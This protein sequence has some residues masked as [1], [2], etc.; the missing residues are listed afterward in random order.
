MTPKGC[1]D[2][3]MLKKCG[4]NGTCTK[5]SAGVASCVCDT[6]FVL[7]TDNRTCTDTCVLKRCGGNGT[8]TKESDG[9]A[10]CVCNV[11][12][13][14]QANNRTCTD[15]CVLKACGGNGTC[16]KDSAGVA[17][18][19]CDVGFV[20]QTNGRTC[21]DTCVLKKCGGNATCIKSST[22]VA[23]CVCNTG[24]MLQPGGTTC[25]DTCA[26][27]AC[28]GNGTCT[29]DSAGV[30]SCVC[31][32]GF[33]LQSD[34]RTCTDTC[35]L[36]RCG[37]N[38]TCVKSTAGV[39]SCVCDSGFEI[40]PDG[41]TCTESCALKACGGN[42]R[43]TKDSAGVASCVCDVGFA[44]QT[45]G[46]T[47]TDTCVLKNCA[48]DTKCV[49]SAAGVASCVCDTDFV[50]QPDGVTCTVMCLLDS[51][52]HSSPSIYLVPLPPS[53]LHADTCAVKSCNLTVSVCMKDAAGMA[54]CVYKTGYQNVSGPST[55][56]VCPAGASCIPVSYSN[57]AYCLFS[58][59]SGMTAVGCVLDATPTVSTTSFTFYTLPSY[60][61]T[62]ATY[63]TRLTY[64]G[65]TNLTASSARDI[66]SY[67]SVQD[68]PGGVGSCLEIRAYYQAGCIGKYNLFPVAKGSLSTSSVPNYYGYPFRSFGC[69]IFEK[70]ALNSCGANGKC[71]QDSAGVAFCAC[72][73]GFV[74]QPDG[75]TCAVG[76][77]SKICDPTTDC[78]RNAAGSATCVCKAGY[79]NIS[80]TCLG[81]ATCGNC[82][83]GATCTVAFGYIPYCICPPGYGMTSTGCISGAVPTV[84]DN[85][86][87]FYDQSNYTITP[88]TYTMRLE[89]NGCTTI[90]SS[91]SSKIRSIWNVQ[92]VSGGVGN[93]ISVNYYT[94]EG[95]VGTYISFPSSGGTGM[96]GSGYINYPT[97]PYRSFTCV[98]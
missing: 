25:T 62:P 19:V 56:G 4:G 49:K 5:D 3:C 87:T 75:R 46:R 64:N 73:A 94:Q 18:C 66:Q 36:K 59:G 54:S 70:C 60:G 71:V 8:C 90:P 12:F 55:C 84:S 92:K 67:G 53:H 17:S 79:R 6:G 15:T 14:L 35:V 10:S 82:P 1:V 58:P 89:Y 80:G 65:C 45:D 63:T 78:V 83:T 52:V 24:F 40:Q 11:G 38:A 37:G 61:V 13:V 95:C 34:G 72:D 47:C 50:L 86:F 9:V 22:G 74:L 33:D 32:T 93:C 81:P 31:D 43:C 77:G 88:N 29:K 48:G 97:Y 27:K 16:T 30:A 39:A 41:T 69:S 7:Q 51:F 28:G 68:A 26:L 21:T 2:T 76:C 44:L 23:S 96:S 98:H 91:T 57:A 42:G 20:L 85:S